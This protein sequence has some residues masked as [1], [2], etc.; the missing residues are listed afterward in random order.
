MIAATRNMD[1]NLRMLE[2]NDYRSYLKAVFKGRSQTNPRYSLRAFA[3]DLGISAG[4]LSLVL[5]NKQGLSVGRAKDIAEKLS[6][7]GKALEAFCLLVEQADSRSKIQ[8]NEAQKKLDNVDLFQY[9]VLPDDAFRMVSD[10][11]HYALHRLL[12]MKITPSDTRYL[13]KRLGISEEEVSAAIERM[14]RLGLLNDV[15]GRLKAVVTR[16]TTTNN[17]PSIA[18]RRYT[19]QLI[20]KALVAIDKQGVEERDI[21]TI[22]LAI[23]DKNIDQF[24]DLIK[25]FRRSMDQAATAE[26]MLSASPPNELYCLSIQF[27]RLSE[28][29]NL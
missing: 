12:Q 19:K 28:K 11:Y 6:L 9:K 25:K 7:S 23:N 26:S 22:T 18:I 2:T 5:N 14:K 4:R 20:N 17:V 3:R 10:W 16:L 27:F 29:I 1:Y 13:A 24:R 8:R 15:K 21:S